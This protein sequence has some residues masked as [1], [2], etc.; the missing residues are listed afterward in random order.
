[1]NSIEID[2]LILGA[3]PSGL[4]LSQLLH[5]QGVRS[6]IVERTSKE[7]VLSRIRAGVLERGTVDAMHE[8]GCADRLESERIDHD[9]LILG[10][11]APAIPRLKCIARDYSACL[12]ADSWAFTCGTLS[13]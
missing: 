1:M 13:L 6:I 2:V 4:I 11:A 8:A 7:G 9:R 3:G 5:Q 10:S 12:D